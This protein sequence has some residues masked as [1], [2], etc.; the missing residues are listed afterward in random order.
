MASPDDGSARMDVALPPRRLSEEYKYV[1][2]RRL[3]G[4]RPINSELKSGA[5]IAAAAAEEDDHTEEVAAGS[6]SGSG[7]SPQKADADGLDTVSSPP[8]SPDRMRRSHRKSFLHR[9]GLR[10]RRTSVSDMRNKLTN[11]GRGSRRE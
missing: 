4:L 6:G 11:P 5:A 1:S 2:V 10:N 7:G 8:A 9:G 3:S